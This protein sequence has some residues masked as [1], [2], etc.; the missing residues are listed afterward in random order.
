[1]LLNKNPFHGQSNRSH[2]LTPTD[3][4]S[5]C[6]LQNR[7]SLLVTVQQNC[8]CVYVSGMFMSA[9]TLRVVEVGGGEGPAGKELVGAAGMASTG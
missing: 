1:M 4:I 8:M 3:A 2:L 9:E 5:T 7:I 6:K